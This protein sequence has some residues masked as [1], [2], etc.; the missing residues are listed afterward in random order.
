MEF[1]DTGEGKHCE[2]KMDNIYNSDNF[3]KAGYNNKIECWLVVLQG[4]EQEAILP[5]VTQEELKS[6]K[7]HIDTRGTAKEAVLEDDP[8]M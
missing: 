7:A 6:N 8:K 4:K 3:I 5:I 1:F 2:W